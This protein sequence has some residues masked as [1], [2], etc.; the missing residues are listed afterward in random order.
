MIDQDRIKTQLNKWMMEFVE[1]PNP[2]L[3]D[4]APCP[5]AKAARINNQIEIIF[6]EISNLF[7]D[8]MACL[9][10]LE[11]KEVIVICFD[12]TQINPIVLQELVAGINKT[13]MP[14]NYVVL[15]DHPNAPEYTNGVKMNFGQCGLFVIQKLDKLNL[16]S[17]QLK[18]KGYYHFWDQAALDNVVT[19]RTK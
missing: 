13:L 19:W 11:S 10:T 2:K 15:E 12:H 7:I 6:S 3:G 1:I 14:T 4:W 16:A 18:D 17:Q 9:P 8:T 5:Y